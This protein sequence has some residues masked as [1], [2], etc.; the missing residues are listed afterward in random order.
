[1]HHAD[2]RNLGYATRTD[3]QELKARSV[4]NNSN[5]RRNGGSHAAIASPRHDAAGCFRALCDECLR[6]RRRAVMNGHNMAG[7]QQICRHADAHVAKPMKPT[8]I[9]NRNG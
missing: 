6:F 2:E 9:I 1:V 5:V 3:A 8:F 7:F 4:K